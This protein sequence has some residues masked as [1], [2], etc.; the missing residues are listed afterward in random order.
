MELWGDDEHYAGTYK[1]ELLQFIHNNHLEQRVLICGKTQDVESVYQRSDIF[2]LPSAFEG[3]SNALGEA[4]SAGL[5]A[6]GFSECPSL[7]EIIQ[8]GKNGLL[9]SP[10][11]DSL[12]NA[13]KYLMSNQALRVQMGKNAHESMAKY[14][15]E[16][17]WE[18]WEN[19]LLDA[20]RQ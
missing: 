11:V 6:V 1:K 17:I 13:L 9:V 15:P 19:V 20:I 2:C 7:D 8:N 3:F 14:A 4:M 10:G 12:A 18:Q 16:V 5:P